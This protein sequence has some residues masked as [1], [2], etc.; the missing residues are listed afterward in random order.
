MSGIDIR[1]LKALRVKNQHLLICLYPRPIDEAL[2]GRNGAQ[3]QRRGLAQRKIL[4]RSRNILQT[5][6]QRQPPPSAA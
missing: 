3:R 2:P 6:N 4:N 1:S 5:G